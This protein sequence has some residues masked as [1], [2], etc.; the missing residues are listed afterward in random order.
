MGF[1]TID[2]LRLAI[3]HEE[4]TLMH[5]HSTDGLLA[6]PHIA[7]DGD[8]IVLG[9]ANRKVLRD[10]GRGNILV[11]GGA[12]YG[13]TSTHA[14]TTLTRHTGSMVVLDLKGQLTEITRHRRSAF[15]RVLVWNPTDPAAT[16]RLNPFAGLGAAGESLARCITMAD[17]MMVPDADQERAD[18]R[19]K[20]LASP[21]L[22]ALLLHLCETDRPTLA[23]LWAV[24][25]AAIAG[26]EFAGASVY[27]RDHLADYRRLEAVLQAGLNNYL[28]AHLSWMGDAAVQ[29]ATGESDLRGRD[30]R[31]G[32]HPTTLYLTVPPRA[33]DR[34]RPLVRLVLTDLLQDLLGH[35]PA[36][37]GLDPR[38]VVL[39]LDDF[40]RAG[41]LDGLEQS[42]AVLP[43]HGVRAVLVARGGAE[44]E[45][46]YSIHN[47]IVANCDTHCLMPGIANLPVWPRGQPN[48]KDMT[49][50]EILS[51]AGGEVLI[52]TQ[53][54]EPTWLGKIARHDARVSY[55]R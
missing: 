37:A 14:L 55:R 1:V 21:L 12:R 48:L 54:V 43:D 9:K 35:R 36:S 26:S 19:M 50:R 33:L 17:R 47:R 2:G 20:E 25:N 41:R 5:D 42:L 34:L 8:G 15:G 27:V 24:V 11:Q 18:N 23:R 13:K 38:P 40:T 44:I 31:E 10:R 49:N 30:L 29:E 39:L 7:T 22:S 45:R 51:R 28:L 16:T 32:D 6:L 46:V 4:M 53:G 52:C 3:S